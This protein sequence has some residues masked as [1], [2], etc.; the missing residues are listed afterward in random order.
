MGQCCST[1]LNLV[2]YSSISKAEAANLN[3]GFEFPT[4]LDSQSED[5][6]ALD[7]VK[8]NP[9]SF[10]NDMSQPTIQ[11]QSDVSTTSCDSSNIVSGHG[12]AIADLALEQDYSY[13]E[14]H[15]IKKRLQDLDKDSTDECKIGISTTRNQKF[16]EILQG[17]GNASSLILAT[18]LMTSMGGLV[19]GDV[20][21]V[22]T[23]LK[24]FP[25][26]IQIYLNGKKIDEFDL[27]RY[28]GTVY[29]AIW[30]PPPHETFTF[31]LCNLEKE[32]KHYDSSIIGKKFLP[33]F[34]D[35]SEKGD[36]FV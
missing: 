23:D 12:L 9:L 16:Y 5:E 20:V 18:K 25:K 26:S 34:N 30:L 13:W 21:G 19:D 11:I 29:P 4:A 22:C 17:D 31:K 33:L 8:N 36:G 7:N 15:V 10:S 35:K 6:E 2:R 27:K 24:S 28:R 3:E 32:F 14:W 1:F